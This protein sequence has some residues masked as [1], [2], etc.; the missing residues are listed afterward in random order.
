MIT[1]VLNTGNDAG[2]YVKDE[3]RARN[4]NLRSGQYLYLS[5]R[6]CWIPV[7]VRYSTQ[8][9]EW[10]FQNLENINVNGQKVMLKND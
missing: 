5:V 1:G 6:D 2:I 7:I 9:Q 4:I 8:K 10:E 3:K